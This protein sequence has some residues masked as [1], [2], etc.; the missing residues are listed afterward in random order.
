LEKH[1]VLNSDARIQPNP[2]EYLHAACLQKQQGAGNSPPKAQPAQQL[3]Q[4][5]Q[6]IVPDLRAQAPQGT[7]QA[8]APQQTQHPFSN[9]NVHV[10]GA[11]TAQDAS[12]P[13][14]A[15]QFAQHLV[16]VLEPRTQQGAQ[17][18]LSDPRLHGSQGSGHVHPGKQNS[19]HPAA[20]VSALQKAPPHVPAVEQE[21]QR[22]FA[23]LKKGG[24]STPDEFKYFLPPARSPVGMKAE[25]APGEVPEQFPAGE[26]AGGGGGGRGTVA[27]VHH[28]PML[29][30]RPQ[31]SSSHQQAKLPF[32]AE[33]QQQVLHYEAMLPASKDPQPTE[34]KEPSKSPAE[35]MKG[36]CAVCSQ[37]VSIHQ[38]RIK[39]AEGMCSCLCSGM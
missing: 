1:Q 6:V 17:Q 26:D 39:N 4:Y 32:S 9:L 3:V 31:M 36:V 16:P 10:F 25:V 14:S 15:P 21:R 7:P 20:M 27:V 33:A 24:D 22:L 35:V 13:H 30:T 38:H 37:M 2:G 8:H 18:V 19:Q 12:Q 34:T 28:V 23:F 5:G 11:H 29:Q